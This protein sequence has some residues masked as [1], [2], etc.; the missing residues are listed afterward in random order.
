[1]PIIGA[2]GASYKPVFGA[3]R[4]THTSHR[5]LIGCLLL[6]VAQVHPVALASPATLYVAPNGSDAW[7][8][9]SASPNP[10]GTDGPFKTLERARDEVRKL[11]KAA[12]LPAGGV[13]VE[14][15][16]GVYELARSFELTLSLIHI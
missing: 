2:G 5:I 13:T 8:G 3:T 10:A 1:M 16:G 11:V 12:S 6:P 9:R 4:M 7:S 14:L 15:Q